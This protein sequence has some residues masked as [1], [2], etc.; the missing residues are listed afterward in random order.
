MAAGGLVNG[1]LKRPTIHLAAQPPS[2]RNSL[3]APV[4]VRTSQAGAELQN[5]LQ[6]RLM[7]V[8]GRG[9]SPL[10]RNASPGPND[11]RC[12]SPRNSLAVA[13][14]QGRLSLPVS[15][16]SYPFAVTQHSA[17]PSRQQSPV[18]SPVSAQSRRPVAS[19][20]GYGNSRLCPQGGYGLSS[21]QPPT[22]VVQPQY[23]PPLLGRGSLTM[24]SPALKPGGAAHGNA[25]PVGA[26]Q[27][28]APA[29][30]AVGHQSVSRPQGSRQTSPGP[31]IKPKRANEVQIVTQ[32]RP[33]RTTEDHLRTELQAARASLH[34]VDLEKDQL[35]KQLEEETLFAKE[36]QEALIFERAKAQQREE[37]WQKKV[38]ELEE[39]M[40]RKSEQRKLELEELVIQSDRRIEAVKAEAAR[41]LEQALKEAEIPQR[42][43]EMLEQQLAER[44]REILEYQAKIYMLEAEVAAGRQLPQRGV[45]VPVANGNVAASSEGRLRSIMAS[46]GSSVGDL[47]EAIKSVESL[48]GEAKRELGI[49]QHRERRAAYEQLH[50]A[51]DQRGGGGGEDS[52]QAALERARMAGLDRED[53]AKA[54]DKLAILRAMTHEERASRDLQQIKLEKRTKAF[55]LVKRDDDVALQGLLE[56]LEAGLQWEDWRDHAGRSLW[57]CAQELKASK[58]QRYLGPILGYVVHDAKDNAAAEDGQPDAEP[59]TDTTTELPSEEASPTVLSDDQ[60][61]T[62][63]VVPETELDAR[64]EPLKHVPSMELMDEEVAATKQKMFRAVVQNDADTLRELLELVPVSVWST[65]TNK[66]EKGLLCLSE[67][68][69]SSDAYSVLAKALGLIEEFKRQVFEEKETVWVFA[70]DAVQPRRATVVETAIEDDDVVLVEFWDD[71]EPAMGVERCMVQKSWH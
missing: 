32:Q 42:H 70:K 26:A 4:T 40:Q 8:E 38:A 22:V 23:S 14:Q 63:T 71:D 15:C 13:P 64:T 6:R 33:Q 27:L 67:E 29:R 16:A 61:S 28:A 34:I 59:D 48:L 18:R 44:D 20:I 5:A 58:V 30:A 53:I 55:L 45:D 11:A 31:D 3:P 10:Q 24:S 21:V 65:W 51:M 57:K 50:T 25:L 17:A 35:Q 7:L 9:T 37:A 49:K 60:K 19:S 12:L 1:R 62:T 54:E 39:K 68:R 56:T 69:G 41:T 2:T 46:S 47:Q 66:A 36:V 52:L 43:A